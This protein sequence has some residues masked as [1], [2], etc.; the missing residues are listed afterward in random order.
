MVVEQV[1]PRWQWA[2]GVGQ[3]VLT[4]IL[5]ALVALSSIPLGVPSQWTWSRISVRPG[6]LDT[7]LA[8][9]ALA[10]YVVVAWLGFRSRAVRGP[11]PARITTRLAQV[12]GLAL[13]GMVLQLVLIS[14]APLG[15]GLARWVT[16]GNDGAS[17]YLNVATRETREG[18]KPFLADYAAW[19]REQDAL[20]IGTHPPGLILAAHTASAM[21]R[22]H[23]DRARAIV[24]SLPPELLH[25]FQVLDPQSTLADRATMVVLGLITLVLAS[26]TIL[27]LYALA[28]TELSASGA[29]AVAAAWPLVPGL[30]LFHPTADTAYPFFATTALALAGWAGRCGRCTGL[31]LAAGSGLLLGV[32]ML[33]SL[34]FL[35]VG[36]IAAFLLWNTNHSWRGW[37]ARLL[38]TGAGFLALCAVFWALTSANPFLI[39]W[40]NQANHARFYTEY[41]RSFLAWV[42]INPIELAASIGAAASVAIAAG[43]VLSGSKARVTLLTFGVLTVLTL[44]GRSL[45]EVA[46]LWLPFVPGLLVASGHWAERAGS[47]SLAIGLTLQGLQV[48]A[49]EAAIQT[50]YPITI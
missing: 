34:V 31:G 49:F 29:W 4:V 45:S 27:P 26:A 43:L 11:Q 3:V 2:V 13:A 32:G 30:I 47:R 24:E 17:G 39:W 42:L 6:I 28:R 16:L 50:V 1:Q 44:S 10:L 46:R 25:S 8:I 35:P 40:A 9:L 7:I 19:V 36:M 21:I 33:F 20:H 41:P 48:L 18:L 22:A 14:A 5:I 37:A 38:A 12:G 15:M 23:P